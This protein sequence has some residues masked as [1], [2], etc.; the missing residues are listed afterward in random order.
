[1]IVSLFD[2]DLKEKEIPLD[3]KQF[4]LRQNLV[5]GLDILMHRGACV[6]WEPEDRR[7]SELLK[8]HIDAK[9]H[10]ILPM[11]PRLVPVYELRPSGDDLTVPPILKKQEGRPFVELDCKRL[12]KGDAIGFLYY[13]SKYSPNPDKPMI[14]L[15]SNITDI[16]SGANCD[17]PV[18]VEN[19][20]LHSW[21]E[22][23][24]HHTHPKFGSFEL[25]PRD[26]TIILP[27]KED[28]A[29]NINLTRLR[30]DGLA[31]IQFDEAVSKMGADDKE[32]LLGNGHISKEQ[33]YLLE[34]TVI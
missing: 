2:K 28:K 3:E 29:Q 34:N 33:C 32:F 6:V 16:P 25:Q 11:T 23:P 20:L 10:D 19:L 27:I 21:K 31:Q 12:G 18:Y 9:T 4:E 30:T 8:K 13:L 5:L 15:I 17:D 22:N 7:M 14:V 26:F 1:M 24:A